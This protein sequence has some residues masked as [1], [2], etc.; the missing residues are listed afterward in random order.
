METLGSAQALE[1]RGN[2]EE[3][4]MLEL[5]NYFTSHTP[6]ESLA[7]FTSKE[8]S[9]ENVKTFFEHQFRKRSPLLVHGFISKYKV[10]V[11]EKPETAVDSVVAKLTLIAHIQRYNWLTQ[12]VH[13]TILSIPAHASL[14]E[15][16]EVKAAVIEKLEQA[17]EANDH[18]C[19]TGLLTAFPD[20]E[21]GEGTDVATLIKDA[22]AAIKEILD[23]EDQ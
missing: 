23:A 17:V 1:A 8:I 14:A 4:L 7:H 9:D 15:D 12:T 21:K 6:K 13:Y 2:S 19:I 16:P 11:G 22:E 20:L 18:N 5:E 3:K 10:Y